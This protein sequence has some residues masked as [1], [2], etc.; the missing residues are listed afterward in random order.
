[1]AVSKSL[2][3]VEPPATGGAALA[4]AGRHLTS[5]DPDRDLLLADRG[6]PGER[7]VL[8]RGQ[9]GAVKLATRRSPN[10]AADDDPAGDAAGRGG[11]P[12]RTVA[13]KGLRLRG[14][15]R[16]RQAAI[17]VEAELHLSLDHGHIVRLEQ[18]YE[19]DEALFLA[20]EALEGGE[21]Y[22]RL[23]SREDGCYGELEAAGA[24]RQILSA[25]AYL[26]GRGIVHRDLKLDNFVYSSNDSD[27]LKL[28]DFGLATRWDGRTEMNY[29]C[30]TLFY[31]APEVMACAYSDKADVWSI[32]VIAYMLLCGCMPWSGTDA[33]IKAMIRAGTPLLS[34][35]EFQQ[36][37]NEAQDFVRSLLVW[38]PDLR[39]SAAAALKHPWICAARPAPCP[40]DSVLVRSLRGFAQASPWERTCLSLVARS[41]QQA[42]CEHLCQ[43]FEDM[44][45]SGTGLLTLAGFQSAFEGRVDESESAAL[46]RK[47]DIDGVG[48]ISLS[49]FL[50]A[51]LHGG[52]IT[53]GTVRLAFSRLD[54]NQDG[55]I[56]AS[57]LQALF[58]PCFEALTARAPWSVAGT[59][60]IE[61]FR[62]SLAVVERPLGN[63]GECRTMRRWRGVG[64]ENAWFSVGDATLKNLVLCKSML[65]GQVRVGSKS[66]VLTA[67]VLLALNA[68]CLAGC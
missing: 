38:N 66:R 42:S 2:P 28:I 47:M 15:P 25:A 22:D 68:V 11:V 59:I 58:G 12:S 50:A 24:L 1:M 46:F 39:L 34:T 10:A 51:G 6:R 26:H 56:T 14:Q 31:M 13:V 16:C 43:Q 65:K 67:F 64:L 36:L 44:D 60:S 55:V 9:S 54:V 19:T 48:A 23:V 7:G 5:K 4:L 3:G 52:N 18:V 61:E 27:R 45:V 40:V 21:L 33:E 41:V 35:P 30:G 37:S 20:M 49:E 32:G 63:E 62:A 29:A 8:G 57:D 53:D 17:R